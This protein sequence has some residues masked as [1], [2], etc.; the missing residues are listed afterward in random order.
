M[1]GVQA[2]VCGGG[3]SVCVLG[4]AGEG[5][6][7][8]GDTRHVCTCVCGH[9]NIVACVCAHACVHVYVCGVYVCTWGVC[10]H[11]CVCGHLSMCVFTCSCV[12]GGGVGWGGVGWGE[13]LEG[14]GGLHGIGAHV[15]VWSF[16]HTCVCVCTHLCVYLVWA[17]VRTS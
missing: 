13:E 1:L 4:H 8:R 16:E 12:S 9:L 15:C 17:V 5:W 11:M 14:E 2:C 3:G 7:K 10:M 6:N